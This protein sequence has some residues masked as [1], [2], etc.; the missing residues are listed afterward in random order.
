MTIYVSAARVDN[1]S[2]EIS[3]GVA[4]FDL[5]GNEPPAS[6]SLSSL[7]PRFAKTLAQIMAKSERVWIRPSIGLPL[8]CLGSPLSHT[9]SFG[10]QKPC[11]RSCPTCL[12]HTRPDT[13]LKSA[14]PLWPNDSAAVSTAFF[15]QASDYLPSK[16][17]PIRAS[18]TLFG[19]SPRLAQWS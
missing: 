8:G 7:D 13:R 16:N 11:F 3:V 6:M 12:T 18:M 4:T 9:L 14:P 2:F 1:N 17:I 19:A 5:M 10:T 15:A